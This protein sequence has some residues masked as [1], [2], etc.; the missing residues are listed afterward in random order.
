LLGGSTLNRFS[1]ETARLGVAAKQ[2]KALQATRAPFG[3]YAVRKAGPSGSIVRSSE[4]DRQRSFTVVSALVEEY[5]MTARM[6]VWC[7]VALLGL[8]VAADGSAHHSYAMFDGSQTKIVNATVAKLEW[9]NPHV[10]LW[11]YVANPASA[12]GYDLYAFENGS[13]N[14]LSQRGWSKTYFTEGEKVAIAYWPLRDGRM[15]GHLAVATRA[16]GTVIHGAGGP[17]GSPDAG[18]AVEAPPVPQ[19]ASP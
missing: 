8:V 14:V 15:G 17:G 18:F 2:S 6:R 9:V 4:C 1:W 11:V 10:F 7:S 13:P 12:T 19:E 5:I 3:I 16:D